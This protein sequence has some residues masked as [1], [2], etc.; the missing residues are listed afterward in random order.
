M[1][2]PSMDWNSVVVLNKAH[3]DV[4]REAT[5]DAVAWMLRA[6]G[7]YG[8]VDMQPRD[9]HVTGIDQ[10][11]INVNRCLAILPGGHPV[12]I[13]IGSD[14]RVI[15]KYEGAARHLNGKDDLIFLDRH[16]KIFL[17]AGDSRET[18]QNCRLSQWSYRISVGPIAPTPTSLEI[19]RIALTQ[20][21]YREDTSFV[22]PC[23]RLN[24]HPNLIAW[25]KALC[26]RAQGCVKA[27]KGGRGAESR[28]SQSAFIAALVPL[29][30]IVDWQSRPLTYLQMVAISLETQSYLL[31]DGSS[32]YDKDNL[33]SARQAIASALEDIFLY[34]G[35]DRPSVG[36]GLQSVLERIERALRAL[37]ELF[38]NGGFHQVTETPRFQVKREGGAAPL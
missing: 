30:M 5:E 29:T 31:E 10:Y 35:V 13:H 18:M 20:S 11:Y 33:K 22:P 21:G 25:M 19:G 23:L 1:P 37:E 3:L 8:V 36:I 14:S 12:D 4:E 27:L 9:L 34:A 16:K 28:A 15:D 38:P 26:L 6:G 32:W 7:T 2:K 17:P 24:S